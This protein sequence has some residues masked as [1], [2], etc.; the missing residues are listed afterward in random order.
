MRIVV[1]GAG[2][3]AV[4]LVTSL[5]QDGFEG[6]LTMVGDE[7]HLPYQRPPLSKTFM[8]DGD[9]SR[10]L[11]KPESFFASN[12]IEVIKGT[13]VTEIDRANKHIVTDRDDT[14]GYDRLVLAIGAENV[15]PPLTGADHPALLELRTLAHAETIR[16]RLA[17]AKQAI[18]IG[19]GFI[20]LEFA[21]MAAL[22]RVTST[23][24]EASSRLMARAVSPAISA[25][26]LDFHRSIG[27]TVLLDA[28]VAE[29]AGSNEGRIESVRLA[30]GQSLAGELVLLAA[31]VKPSTTLAEKAGLQCRNG[32]VVDGQLTTDDPAIFAIGDCA[33]VLT[34]DGIHQRLESVQ[35]ATDQA[36]HLSRYLAKGEGGTSYHA[37]PWFWSDQGDQKLQIAGLPSAAN[38][39]EARPGDGSCLTVLGYRDDHLVSVETVNAAGD[40]MAAR[41]LLAL[42]GSLTRARIEADGHDLRAIAKSMAPPT[43]RR[44]RA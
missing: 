15:R 37:V 24:T 19:G 35:A 16:E 22:Q 12:Q 23:V 28:P 18:V 30:D 34:I 11:L 26:F 9:A 21:A 29:I 7:P 6:T 41:R 42:P 31:G 38:Y 2:H 14:I 33:A 3:A 43:L 44:A 4:Q 27:N 5:R 8:K 1:V 36:K 32:I 17:V 40:H 39:F 25:H 13:R 20:G 10:L